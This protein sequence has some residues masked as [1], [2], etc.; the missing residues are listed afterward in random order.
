[1]ENQGVDY[2]SVT[3]MLTTFLMQFFTDIQG[4]IVVMVGLSTLAYNGLRI[5]NEFLKKKKAGSKSENI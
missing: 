1:M 2:Y 5:Y 4:V 3:G